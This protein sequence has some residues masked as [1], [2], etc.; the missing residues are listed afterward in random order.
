MGIIGMLLM[1][2]FDSIRWRLKNQMLCFLFTFNFRRNPPL[3]NTSVQ[4]SSLSVLILPLAITFSSVVL[5]IYLHYLPHPPLSDKQLFYPE[6]KASQLLSVSSKLVIH[7]FRWLK[8]LGT[9]ALRFVS[10]SS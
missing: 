4:Q 9:R 8:Q 7:S 1:E 5:N 10:A 2:S 3:A 6:L